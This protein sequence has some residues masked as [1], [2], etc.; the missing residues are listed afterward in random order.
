MNQIDRTSERLEQLYKTKTQK[1]IEQKALSDEASTILS[2]LNNSS[3]Q[4]RK[5][6]SAAIAVAKKPGYFDYYEPNNDIKSIESNHILK[7]I[8]NQIGA[9]T[10][11]LQVINEEISSIKLI[12]SQQKPPDLGITKISQWFEVYGQ[13]KNDDMD[14]LTSFSVC[15]KIYGG[16]SHHRSFKSLSSTMKKGRITK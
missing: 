15:R 14:R 13:P 16:T 5:N 2:K 6:L 7:K 1:L 8:T 4:A 12:H 3:L 11:E 10:T 9:L